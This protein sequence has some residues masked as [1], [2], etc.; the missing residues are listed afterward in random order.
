MSTTVW[1]VC[2]F[3]N[4]IYV[5]III[6]SPTALYPISLLLLQYSVPT[7]LFVSRSDRPVHNTMYLPMHNIIYY[8]IINLKYI[9]S[10]VCF[11][12]ITCFYYDTLVHLK[13]IKDVGTQYTLQSNT[14]NQV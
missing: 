2:T 5:I 6:S 1:F 11:I 12:N 8:I 7:L 4:I 3:N 10:A 13:F 9:I 14:Y